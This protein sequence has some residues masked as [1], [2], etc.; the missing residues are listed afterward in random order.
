MVIDYEALSDTEKADGITVTVQASDGT[1]NA[2][3]DVT[4]TIND[5]D[6]GPLSAPA[7]NVAVSVYPNPAS[8]VVRFVGLSAGRTYLYKVYSLVGHQVAKGSLQ[9]G[10]AIELA[11]LSSGQYILV[12]EGKEGSEAFR[13][14]LQ[15]L[16]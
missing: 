1:N 9:G 5:V 14:Q 13:T 10:S 15:V 16:K 4:L 7:A 8:K 12:L 3:T 2:T 6:E 11:G